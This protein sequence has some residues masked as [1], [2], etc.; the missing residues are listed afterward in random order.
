MQRN[1]EFYRLLIRRSLVRVQVGEPKFKSP[2]TKV[3]GL[4]FF[5]LPPCTL[6]DPIAAS[7]AR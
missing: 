5:E 1:A 2:Q 3:C 4:F 6:G 7:G